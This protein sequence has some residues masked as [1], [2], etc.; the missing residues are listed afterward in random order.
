MIHRHS[1]RYLFY[2]STLFDSRFKTLQQNLQVY[3]K[4]IINP[5]ADKC[6]D[7]ANIIMVV[8]KAKT[9]P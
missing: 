4:N 2:Y 9:N 6:N 8:K 1:S 3:D 5:F 7:S